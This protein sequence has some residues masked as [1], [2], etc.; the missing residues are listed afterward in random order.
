MNKRVFKNE[1]LS[2]EQDRMR[3]LII[4]ISL[5][6]FVATTILTGTFNVREDLIGTILNGITALLLA[7]SMVTAWFGF[8]SFGRFAIPLAAIVSITYLAVIGDGIYNPSN[9]AFAIVIAIAALLLGARGLIIYGAL[10]VVAIFVIIFTGM[11]G[12]YQHTTV[13]APDIIA[14]LM[15][16]LV[17]TIIL[18]IYT[19][20]LELRLSD[21][22]RSE[23][24]QIRINQE[25][26][27][28]RD[29]LEKQTQELAQANVLSTHRVEQLR[30]VAEVA[31]SAASIQE[32]ERLLG[33]ITDL[34]SKRFGV[35]HAGIFLLDNSRE[36]ATL[37][38]A[39]S[40]DGKK[41]MMH[42]H[43]MQTN[44]QGI[45][46]TVI[47]TGAPRIVMDVGMDSTYVNDHNLPHTR[48]EIT[49]PLKIAGEIIG[50]LDLQSE[51][52]SS[53]SQE[54]IEVLSILSNQLAIA[55][56]NARSFESIRRAI[57]DAETAYQQL[58]G[59][60]WSQFTKGQLM[61]GYHFDGVEA[62]SIT[63]G[64]KEATGTALQV[65]VRLRG[66][67][68]GRLKLTSL[69]S[70]RIWTEDEIAMTES[71]AERAA[72]SLENARLLE[73]AQKH[74]A[75]ERTISE[76][77]A[78]VS[79]ALDIEGILQTTAEELERALGGSEVII[80]LES[81]E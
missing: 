64:Q 44:S 19:R 77:T 43:R 55:I 75:K 81:E 78:R 62:R 32:L 17:T 74:A 72:L 14:A 71:I 34:I 26:L 67:E 40:V 57:Q 46:G 25:L 79:V 51:E 56:Q 4:I 29:S 8:T 66:R 20:Q 28:T 70:D 61:P 42:G 39:S 76:G 50:A 15:G 22:R 3:K 2:P 80:Q 60:T 47:T 36:Y 35:Y 59:E 63:E 41:M 27:E 30:L 18:Y 1:K 6:G 37:R 49:L 58:T 33:T 53:F 45:V 54:N 16:L 12:I 48:S 21:T 73:D 69:G 11:L 38:A 23:Q 31:N 68:I 24:V 13:T 5:I 7:I 9:L 10:S 52:P 65:P